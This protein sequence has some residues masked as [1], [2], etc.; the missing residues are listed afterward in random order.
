MYLYL[1]CVRYRRREE[2]WLQN[3]LSCGCSLWRIARANADEIGAAACRGI[4]FIDNNISQKFS[5]YTTLK[6]PA[7]YLLKPSYIAFNL[8]MTW[9]YTRRLDKS[10]VK[11]LALVK[12]ISI[13]RPN[14]SRNCYLKIFYHV[15]ICLVQIEDS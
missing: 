9:D 2:C 4:L 11:L 1:A 5:L 3:I 8:R 6:N 13:H 12:N 10:F 15:K 7:N 14:Y